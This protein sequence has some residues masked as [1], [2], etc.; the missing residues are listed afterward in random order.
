MSKQTNH[1]GWI[2]L[3]RKIQD[4]FLWKQR[5]SFSKL[6]AWIDILMEV[7]HSEKPQKVLF[8]NTLLTCNYGESLK[9]INTWA[10][11]WRWSRNK[12]YRFFR[13]LKT[14]NMIEHKTE[15]LTTR[16]TVCNY[17]RYDPKQNKTEH[18]TDTKRNTDKNDKNV[19]KY[20]YKYIYSAIDLQLSELLFRL[21]Q[22]K[23]PDFPE[24]NFEAWANDVRKLREI[25]KRTPEQIRAVIEW[26]QG[27]DFWWDKVL[28]VGSLRKKSKTDSVKRIDR[29]EIQMQR[30]K[31]GSGKAGRVFTGDSEVG[32][33][34]EA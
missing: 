30:R 4:N 28:S 10:E 27:D 20:I 15:H 7:Q 31:N 16:L 12:V 9:S 21:I 23:K 25:D 1:N 26:S 34:I 5:G 11:R 13:M 3:H 32:E 2:A 24:P 14:E 33:T 19:N 17:K 29:I 22:Q 6:E 8:R 18:Q